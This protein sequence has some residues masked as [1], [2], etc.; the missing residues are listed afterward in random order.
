MDIHSRG[1]PYAQIIFLHFPGSGRAYFI[2]DIRIPRAC[3]QRCT[4]PCCGTYTHGRPDSHACRSVCRHQVRDSVL[5]KISHAERIGNTRIGL[6]AKQIDQLSVGQLRQEL[7]HCYLTVYHVYQHGFFRRRTLSHSLGNG[8]ARPVSFVRRLALHEIRAHINSTVRLYRKRLIAAVGKHSLFQQNRR[9][10]LLK[11]HCHTIL[12]FH[13][14]VRKLHGIPYGIAQMESILSCFHYICG[15]G[16]FSGI[17]IACHAVNRKIKSHL[18]GFSRLQTTGFRK[19]AQHLGRLAQL[20]LRRAVIK[21]HHFFSSNAACVRHTGLRCNLRHSIHLLKPCADTLNRKGSIGK[22]VSKRIIHLFRRPGNRLK[23]PVAHINIFRILHIILGFVKVCGGRIIIKGTGKGIHQLAGRIHIP[24]QN[25]SHGKAAFNSRLPC[26]Q[27]TLDPVIVLKP[28]RIHHTAHIQHYRYPGE[29]RRNSVNH[30]LLL[31]RKVKITIAGNSLPVPAFTRK[32]A[33]SNHRSV[34]KTS[35]CLQ[36]L[37]RNSRLHGFSVFLSPR[38]LLLY[39]FLIKMGK[40][41]KYLKLSFRFLYLEP[42]INIT[43]IRGCN[44]AAS[45]ASPH[46]I[47]LS[48]SEN[49]GLASSFQRQHPAFIFQKNHPFCRCR[50]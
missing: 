14:P 13:I 36:Q 44:F 19:C 7:L 21:L 16:N 8:V 26:Q 4:G 42:F 33:D 18:L 40:C 29:S 28:G 10:T 1:Q 3:Q 9:H 35:G 41:I 31:R 25:I 15:F 47:N 27:H 11:L 45:A 46:V 24:T 37:L 17:I 6:A 5:R 50:S 22:P 38:I 34:R 39:I 12:F 20:T 48:F 32:T 43:R 2:D 30:R 49:R 23:I